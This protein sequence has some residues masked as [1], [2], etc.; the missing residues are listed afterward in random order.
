VARGGHR[1][2]KRAR[3]P[4][5]RVR[6]GVRARRIG[7]EGSWLHVEVEDDGRSFDPFGEC[8]K[9]FGLFSLRERL[10]DLGGR[11]AIDPRPG[12]GTRVALAVPLDRPAPQCAAQE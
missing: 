9:G 6:R 4:R 2:W 7:R 10:A 11:L 12:R 8:S 5:Q 3:D 1:A